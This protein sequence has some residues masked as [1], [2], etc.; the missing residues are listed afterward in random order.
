M[1]RERTVHTTGAVSVAVLA[2]VVAMAASV[3]FALNNTEL[4]TLFFKGNELF[5]QANDLA[6]KDPTQA[7]G[8]Y[9]KAALR[10]ERIVQDGNIHNGRL[11]YNIGNIYFRMGDL[12]RAI[13]NYR[14]AAQYT[15]NDPNLIQNLRYARSRCADRV[16]EPQQ[17]KILKTLLFWHYDFS[18]RTRSIIFAV[19]F[20]ALWVSAAVRLLRKRLV[21]RWVVA[22]LGIV[23][24]VFLTSVLAE[25]WVSA[26]E[27][28]GVI[29]AEQVVARKGDSTAYEP[30][31][32]DPLHAGTEF[33]VVE[34]RGDW[35]HVRLL[36]DRSCWL[37]KKD[38]G[39]VR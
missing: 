6:A 20:I 33:D 29:I 27:R 26:H 23:T 30:S 1:R 22:V 34:D 19:C 39:L 38:I 4:Q 13:L 25:A 16:D 17:T 31:F 11:Y 8:L 18:M 21:P 5:H 9:R 35:V 14:R 36:D 2:C 28:S 7:E 15:P 3:V 12:G 32:K 24:V 37:P 10:F